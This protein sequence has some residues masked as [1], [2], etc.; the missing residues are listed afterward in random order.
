[1]PPVAEAMNLQSTLPFAA[2]LQIGVAGGGGLPSTR[3]E[4]L[5]PGMLVVVVDVVAVDVVVVVAGAVV[6]VVDVVA[7][8]EVVATGVGDVSPPPQPAPASAIAATTTA[9]P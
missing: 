9:R 3:N 5:S 1:V 4:A 2:A 8:E 7:T 6:V